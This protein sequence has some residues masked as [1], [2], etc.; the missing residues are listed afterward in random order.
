MGNETED[1]QLNRSDGMARNEGSKS[2]K[3]QQRHQDERDQNH[4]KQPLQRRER[5]DEDPKKQQQQYNLQKSTERDSA[6]TPKP[7]QRN[8]K[9]RFEQTKPA[10]LSPTKKQQQRHRREEE[11]ED[12]D[13]IWNCLLYTSPSPRDGLLSRMPSSA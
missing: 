2:A 1:P 11:D 3:N 10:D 8:N 12:D 9:D 5:F 13:D 7:A 6:S 4:S